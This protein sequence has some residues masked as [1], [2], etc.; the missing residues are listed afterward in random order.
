MLALL[1]LMLAKRWM[2]ARLFLLCGLLF[3]FN[4]LAV[5][6]ENLYSAQVMVQSQS[7]ND[8]TQALKQALQAVLLKVGGQTSVLTHPQIIS[9]LSRAERFVSQYGYARIDQQLWLNVRFDENKINQI[10]SAAALPIWG[11]L[12]PQ[13]LLWLIDEQQFSRSIIGENGQEQTVK[14]VYDFAKQR[15]L[16][17][18]LPI[19]DLQQA[20]QINVADLWGRF[21]QPIFDYSVRYQAESLAVIRLSDFSLVSPMTD[22][23]EQCSLCQSQITGDVT[24]FNQDTVFNQSFTANTKQQVLIQAL[25]ALA[26]QVFVQYAQSSAAQNKLAIE[27]TAISTLM[28]YQQVVDFLENLSSVQAVTLTQRN[29]TSYQFSIEVSGQASTLL[30]ALKLTKQLVQQVDPLA[31]PDLDAIP[32]FVWSANDR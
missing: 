10:F 1:F 20:D 32:R 26:E 28:Q 9:Q 6:V 14:Q 22:A 30:A 25:Q 4:S 23:T 29:N 11:N 15:G 3:S 21:K 24:L 12:R 27:V 18:R 8:R 19:I 17:I 5:E 7:S 2:L 16:P 13:T 31:L